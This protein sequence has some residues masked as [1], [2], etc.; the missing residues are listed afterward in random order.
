MLQTKRHMSKHTFIPPS[1]PGC[2][3]WFDASRSTLPPAA[4]MAS[5]FTLANSET[6]SIADNASLSGGTGKRFSTAAW[7]WADSLAAGGTRTIVS[8][9]GAANREFRVFQ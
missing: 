8:K 1:L 2:Q 9:W 5:Q 4:G 7:I 3:L 6:L